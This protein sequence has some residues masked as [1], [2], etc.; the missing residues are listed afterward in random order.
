MSNNLD[1]LMNGNVHSNTSNN[2]SPYKVLYEMLDAIRNQYHWDSEEELRS[3]C[4]R[5]ANKQKE[6]F[7]EKDS[8]Q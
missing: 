2:D 3:S 1:A 8:E 7:K 4:I 5:A 6:I